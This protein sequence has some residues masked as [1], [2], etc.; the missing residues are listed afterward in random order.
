MKGEQQVCAGCGYPV[1]ISEHAPDCT[2]NKESKE[3]GDFALARAAAIEAIGGQDYAERE[4]SNE[5]FVQAVDQSMLESV[6][7]LPEE[8][9][10]ELGTVDVDVLNQ[11]AREIEGLLEDEKDVQ[12]RSELQIELIYQFIVM[13]SRVQGAGDKAITPTLARDLKEMD[14]TLSSWSLKEKLSNS[15][16]ED[17]DFQFGYPANHAVGMV[18]LAD[19]RQLYVD[20]QNGFAAQVELT[21]VKDDSQT[22][23]AYPIYEMK[24]LQRLS[25]EIPGEGEVSL[26][27]PNGSDFVPQFVGVR[28]DGAL[29]TLGN[30]HMLVNPNSPIFQTRAAEQFRERLNNDPKQ[31]EAF[32]RQVDTIAGGAVIQE[33]KFYHEQES[34]GPEWKKPSFEEEMGEFEGA[35]E[36]LGISVELLREAFDQ[37]SL[38]DLMDADW[39]ELQNSD[40]RDPSWTLDEIVQWLGNR[41]IDGA[42][43]S[44]DVDRLL[45][46]FDSGSELPAPI[47]VFRKDAPPHLVAGNS[48]LL[49]SRAKGVTPKV[50][51]LRSDKF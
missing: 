25:A 23:T 15:T 27:R 32:Q 51:A 20:A 28:E 24:V 18:E 1:Q 40:S 19:G 8:L 5:A 10:S 50:L 45:Q 17:I 36:R 38:E 21:E 7:G 43:Q 42:D 13:I 29:H 30:M 9:A 49:V 2:V 37:A 4:M 47:V 48:R 39:S 3:Q 22:E 16:V 14:C 31:W 33:T 34:S 26:G 6:H 46:G 41:K 35:S 11:R 12:K 44:R